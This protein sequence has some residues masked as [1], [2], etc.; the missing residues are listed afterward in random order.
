MSAEYIA[1][2]RVRLQRPIDLNILIETNR[3]ATASRKLS[4]A[5]TATESGHRQISKLGYRRSLDFGLVLSQ[6]H[7]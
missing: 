5:L 1:P 2:S 4:G 7:S 3:M 6:D